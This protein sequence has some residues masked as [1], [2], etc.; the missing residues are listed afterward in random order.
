V[1]QV[2]DS[3]DRTRKVSFD[4]F[5]HTIDDDNPMKQIGNSDTL[6]LTPNV[7]ITADVHGHNN[8]N[9]TAIKDIPIHTTIL[10]SY[11]EAEPLLI[12]S[13]EPST[14]PKKDNRQPTLDH[15]YG[16]DKDDHHD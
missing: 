14:P 7:S 2:I 4:D 11:D 9:F 12:R 6:S 3:N 10:A 5:L 16:D 15:Y 8:L 13:L 1:G